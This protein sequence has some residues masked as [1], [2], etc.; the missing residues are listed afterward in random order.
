MSLISE[1]TPPTPFGCPDCGAALGTYHQASCPRVGNGQTPREVTAVSPGP[2][3][4]LADIRRNGWKV[5]VHN[6]YTYKQVDFTFWLFTHRTGVFVRGEGATDLDALRE[7]VSEIKRR[8]L[9]FG[10]LEPNSAKQGAVNGDQIDTRS[11]NRK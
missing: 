5:A 10:E 9:T 6:D 2:F 7:V 8:G 11:G 4:L 3:Q 1:P